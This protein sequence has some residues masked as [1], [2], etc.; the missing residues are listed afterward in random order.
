MN[1]QLE[2]KCFLG[3]F[4]FFLSFLFSSKKVFEMRRGGAEEASA[5]ESR[6]PDPCRPAENTDE[7]SKVSFEVSTV[8]KFR[9]LGAGMHRRRA[10][11]A[12]RT[13]MRVSRNF[14]ETSKKVS[15][16]RES[17]FRN[18]EASL[19]FLSKFRNF[20][21]NHIGVRAASSARRRCNPAPKL[22]NF[23]Q[24]QKL[25]TKIKRE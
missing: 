3:F 5:R 7:V 18:C 15:K 2:E 19:K 20:L 25:P 22:R 6:A 21:E 12:A 10:L 17:F 23:E 9:S 11:E 13:T 1:L 16:L 4:F 14:E 24:K 8:S